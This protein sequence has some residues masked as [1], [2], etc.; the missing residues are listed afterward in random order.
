MKS[1]KKKLKMKNKSNTKNNKYTIKKSDEENKNTIINN[2][3]I[4]KIEIL[5]NEMFIDIKK[6]NNLNILIRYLS[7]PLRCLM[8]LTIKIH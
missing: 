4:E 5:K 3:S 8:R 2:L 7:K 6:I 1:D